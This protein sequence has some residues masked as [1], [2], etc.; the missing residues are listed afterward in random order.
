MSDS[1]QPP[2]KKKRAKRKEPDFIIDP[3]NPNKTIELETADLL[4]LGQHGTIQEII[5]QRT[6]EL[7]LAELEELRPG[8][9][10]DDDKVIVD[11]GPDPDAPPKEQTVFVEM[12]GDD[13]RAQAQAAGVD[14]PARGSPTLPPAVMAASGA[15]VVATPIRAT[16][17]MNV[18]RV[19]PT[20]PR[21]SVPTRGSSEL[22]V[23]RRRGGAWLVVLLYVLA[24]SAL[25]FSLYDRFGA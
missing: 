14:V 21:V 24:A 11:L 20:M 17:P 2:R 7:Q 12:E 16:S 18:Q 5:R 23:P 4:Q 6:R 10:I 1:A 9:S 15:A 8:A 3:N 22:R 19:T 13:P 25:A